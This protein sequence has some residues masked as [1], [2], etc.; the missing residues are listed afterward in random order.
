MENHASKLTFPHTFTHFR[1]M[2]A[3]VDQGKEAK[4]NEQKKVA[5]RP[6]PLAAT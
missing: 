3:V 6:G 4:L 5:V 1:D 2:T